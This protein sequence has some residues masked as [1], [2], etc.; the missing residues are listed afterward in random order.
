MHTV[1]LAADGIRVKLEGHL[2]IP[3]ERTLGCTWRQ[4]WL[5]NVFLAT[6]AVLF[7]LWSPAGRVRG[8]WENREGLSNGEYILGKPQAR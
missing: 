1:N 3:I 8:Y 2:E 7:G 6:S 4:F 5:E